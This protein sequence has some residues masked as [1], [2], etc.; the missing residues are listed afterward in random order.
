MISYRWDAVPQLLPDIFARLV[1]YVLN[2]FLSLLIPRLRSP[3][4]RPTPCLL[5]LYRVARSLHRQ[6]LISQTTCDTSHALSSSSDLE[7][8]AVYSVFHT[9]YVA[10]QAP[11]LSRS[12]LTSYVLRLCSLLPGAAEKRRLNSQL[13][14]SSAAAQ[15]LPHASCNF[16]PPSVRVTIRF[17]L[18]PLTSSRTHLGAYLSACI[19]LCLSGQPLYFSGNF[20]SLTTYHASLISCRAGPITCFVVSRGSNLSSLVSHPL[21]CMVGSLTRYM[22]L[23]VSGLIPLF[24]YHLLRCHLS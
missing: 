1:H 13:L 10:L 5:V 3:T 6:P 8:V 19:S 9:S 15:L 21:S 11:Y 23:F 12:V 17:Y 14:R 20:V 18:S 16:P 24:C 22:F 4:T 2:L 7:P